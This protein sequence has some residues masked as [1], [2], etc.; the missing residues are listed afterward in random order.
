[1]RLAGT[2]PRREQQSFPPWGSRRTPEKG[3]EAAAPAVA[4]SKVRGRLPK[5]LLAAKEIWLLVDHLFKNACHQEDLF[6]TP[7]MQD[8]LQEITEGLD[9]SIPETILGSDHSVAEALLIF[10]EAVPEPVLCYELYQRCLECSHDSHLCRQ[11]ICQLPRSHQNVFRFVVAFLRELLK[12]SESNNVSG[13]MLATLFASLLLRPLPNV[14]PSAIGFLLG[15]LLGADDYESLKKPKLPLKLHSLIVHAAFA[16]V[17]EVKT[18]PDKQELRG[19]TTSAIAA[20]RQLT[21][22]GISWLMSCARRL[23]CLKMT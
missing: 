18:E 20:E 7:G 16:A 22:S 3:T 17:I 10:L 21:A 15:F 9:T 19:Y 23:S 4:Y 5:K 1:M 14:L 13:N 11:V 2:W 8:E 12:Y 6:Q